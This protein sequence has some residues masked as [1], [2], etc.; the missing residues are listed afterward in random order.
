FDIDEDVD[1]DGLADCADYCPVYAQPLA[2]G[3]GR[4]GFPIGTL[5]EAIDL[6]GESGCNEVRAYHGTYYENV[7]WNGW[8]VN[9]ESVSGASGTIIDGQGLDSVVAFE[10]AEGEDA[11][12]YGFTLTN[13]GG[14]EGPGI[15]VR[16]ASPTIEGNLIRGNVAN[17]GN[18]LAGGIRVYEGDPVIVD[19][20]ITDN[21]AGYG[22]PEN[23]CDGGGINIRG[24]SAYIAGNLIADNTAGDGGGIWIAYSDAVIVNNVISGN[25]ARDADTVAGGQGG[26]INVQLAGPNGPY[27]A[28]NLITDN[29]AS[30]F[31]GGIVTYEANDLYPSARITNNTIVFNEVTD[32]DNGAGVCQWRRTT[33]TFTNNIIAYND[34]V[35]VFSED[36]MDATFTY[37]LVYGNTTNYSGLAGDGGG[38]ISADPRF[39]G[40]SNDADWTN[41]DFTLLSGSPAIDA[42]DPGTSDADGSRAD[43]GAYGG[44]SGAW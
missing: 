36:D 43:V 37:N 8:P 13:G 40:V 5:Q 11:R 38:N 39:A 24:G 34:G 16:Y 9:A 3:D 28:S 20:E 41:D 25:E 18:W 35:G 33:P 4:V 17:A 32:T 2:T 29:V 27:I 19:N 44:P 42:G 26:G 23:G 30:M 14:G 12:I 1:A 7:S 6:A 15:R 10:T 22:G 31:G 21:D